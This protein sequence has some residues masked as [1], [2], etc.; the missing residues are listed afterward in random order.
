VDTDISWQL[1]NFEFDLLW[2]MLLKLFK[3]MHQSNIVLII[4]YHY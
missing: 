3:S 4:C 2:N 1:L